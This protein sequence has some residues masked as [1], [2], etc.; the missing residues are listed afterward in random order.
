MFDFI[1]N[2]KRIVQ[3]VLAII[4]LPFAFFGV[5]SYMRESGGGNYV[6]SVGGHKISQQEFSQALRQQQERVR[7]ML[8]GGADAALLESP[9]MR[10]AALNSLIQRRVLLEEAQRGRLVAT[11]AQLREFIGELPA[12]KLNGTFN[13]AQYEAFLKSQGMTPLA[14]ESRVRQDLILQQ[15]SDAY[16]R[17]E[18]VP[19]V[20]AERFIQIAEQ[21]REVSRATISPERFVAEVK[22]APD[23]AKTYYDGHP[24]E[25]EVPEQVRLEYVLLSPDA[26]AP[27]VNVTPEEEQQYYKDNAARYGKPEERD[28]SH[29]LVTV[30]QDA[31]PEQKAAAKARAEELA[32]QAKQNP[33][34][35]AELARKNS[36]D[37]GSS[38]NG[39]SLGYNPRG[40]MVKPFDDAVFAMK[41][42][43]VVGPVQTDF[44][45]HVI[46]LNAV[47][48]AQVLDFAQ[49]KESIDADIRKQKAQKLFADLAEKFSNTAYE[50]SDSLKPAADL[51]KLKVEQSPWVPRKGGGLPLF[52]NEK[53]LQAV[54]SEEAV[55]NK[56]NTEAVEVAPN[57]LI[58]ARVLEHKAATKRP[59]EEVKAE[60]SQRLL[61]QQA[62]QQAE[63]IG[64]ESL[65]KLRAGQAVDGLQWSSP[66]MVS[67]QEPKGLDEAAIQSV[68]SADSSKLPAYAGAG[69]PGGGYAL[70]RIARVVEPSADEAK[71]NTAARQLQQTIGQE[72]LTAALSALKAGAEVKIRPGALDKKSGG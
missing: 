56:R 47:K 22:L 43:E 3:I 4:A 1:H 29:I 20:L 31:T 24:A 16:S 26:L 42:G 35:F 68:F 15:A 52:G 38:Q 64:Q 27:Q 12:F 71:R 5:E 11:D 33:D 69:V 45:Y 51:V 65:A 23:A 57:T 30:A 2:N 54:F 49:V 37:P 18:I 61:L 59:F 32:K 28:A 60:I 19:A 58:A 67:R 46:K 63:K 36:Q 21:Q 72:E 40:A 50:Q 9:E 13:S 7:E 70:F 8:G 34:N 10:M 66:E 62:S 39:G 48:P 41:V 44:G 6:A 25:F 14:F 53:L 55:R 17:T